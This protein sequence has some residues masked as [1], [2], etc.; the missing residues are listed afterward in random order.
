MTD[1]ELFKHFDPLKNSANEIPDEKGVYLFLLKTNAN[2]PKVDCVYSCRKLHDRDIIYI[3]ISN[4][5]LRRRDFKQHF[6]GNAGISTLRKSIG[7]LMGLQKIP[8]SK[9]KIDGKTKI[10]SINDAWKRND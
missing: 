5:S 10:H 2:L 7:S 8:R 9:T 6:Y 3:G 4:K 1:P